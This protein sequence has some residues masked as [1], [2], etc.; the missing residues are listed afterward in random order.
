MNVEE[1]KMLM[2]EIHSMIAEKARINK[3]IDYQIKHKIDYLK[4]NG[5]IFDYYT[6]AKASKILKKHICETLQIPYNSFES[7]KRIKAYV[8]ARAVFAYSMYK[9]TDAT[10]MEIGLEIGKRHHST[11]MHL[12]S[13]IEAV[14]EY[15]YFEYNKMN[16]ELV[17]S[18]ANKLKFFVKKTKLI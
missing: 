11:V 4:S 10:L 17:E 2:S 5:I 9:Y 18:A 8:T 1:S 14:L 16:V 7:G 12:I 13:K 15:R 3:I 6:K